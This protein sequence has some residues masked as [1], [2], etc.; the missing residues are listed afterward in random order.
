MALACGLSDDPEPLIQAHKTKL[1][2]TLGG[3]GSANTNF[4]N[5]AYRRIGYEDAAVEVQKLFVDGKREEAAGRVPEELVLR[6]TLIGDEAR[7]RERIRAYRDSGIT[8]LHL[9]PLAAS[10]EDRLKLISRMVELVRE[11]TGAAVAA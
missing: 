7:V 6:T 10:Y 3:M 9:N 1:A 5:A 2:F 8:I 4:Y 11:E